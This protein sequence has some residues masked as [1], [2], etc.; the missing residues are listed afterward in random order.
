MIVKL[1][2]KGQLLITAI[3]CIAL[4]VRVEAVCA[5]NIR[6]VAAN[7]EFIWFNGKQPVTYALSES[8]SPVVTV[9][10]DMFKDDMRQVTGLLPQKTPSGTAVI[11]IIQL[12]KK[13]F[14]NKETS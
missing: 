13:S 4:F 1:K 6:E 2:G 14:C 11:D 3:A 7:S 9:A 8:V 5:A 10:L 12:D